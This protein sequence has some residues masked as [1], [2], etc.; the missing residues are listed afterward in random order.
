[1]FSHDPHGL[2]RDKYISSHL[3]HEW[4]SEMDI[5]TAGLPGHM[6][7]TPMNK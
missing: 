5:Y 2:C 6:L 4:Q 7:I 3:S 1:M